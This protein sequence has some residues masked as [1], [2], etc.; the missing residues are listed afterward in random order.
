VYSDRSRG[1][2]AQQLEIRRGFS[3]YQQ[4]TLYD[5][6]GDGSFGYYGYA[7]AGWELQQPGRL[8]RGAPNY[9]FEGSMRQQHPQQ[10]NLRI[11]AGRVAGTTNLTLS[12]GSS[13]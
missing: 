8:P 9:V 4:N 12:L 5:Y 6:F 13:L 11:R 2:R 10:G 7:R 1:T 3:N